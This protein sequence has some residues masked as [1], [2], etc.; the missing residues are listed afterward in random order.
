MIDPW[1]NIE[2]HPM[3]WNR[4]LVETV[5]ESHMTLTPEE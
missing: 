5:A 2:Y 4:Q 1:R 3:L